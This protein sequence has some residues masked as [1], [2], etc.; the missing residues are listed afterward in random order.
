MQTLNILGVYLTFLQ[1]L[2][3]CLSE[4]SKN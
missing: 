2:H 4:L 1:Q 3:F